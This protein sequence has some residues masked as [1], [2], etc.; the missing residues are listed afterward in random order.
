LAGVI[1]QQGDFAVRQ[2]FDR[3]SPVDDLIVID[4]QAHM[5]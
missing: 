1:R 2:W 3:Q 4:R 5:P